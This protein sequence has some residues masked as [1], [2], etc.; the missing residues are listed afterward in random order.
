MSGNT[1]TTKDVD[2]RVSKVF[3][4]KRTPRSAAYRAGVRAIF[5][6][7]MRQ[8]P[9]V[10][11]WSAGTGEFDA[12][13]AGCAEGYQAYAAMLVEERTAQERAAREQAR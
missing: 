11:Q 13:Y 4:G 6:H 1:W 7:Y 12:F 10:C 5:N 9:T 8:V 2:A 3:S